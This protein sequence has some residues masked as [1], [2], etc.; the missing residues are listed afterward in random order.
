MNRRQQI[1]GVDK[2]NDEIWKLW[3]D[4]PHEAGFIIPKFI[5]EPTKKE[6]LLFLGLNPS[7]PKAGNWQDHDK[8]K[9]LLGRIKKLGL[10][11][12]KK[13]KETDYRRAFLWGR[14]EKA[15]DKDR[16]NPSITFSLQNT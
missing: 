12:V 13:E 2:I 15:C 1:N 4:H 16:K 14:F 5:K 10:F 11:D 8:W 7:F 6:T 9:N 3:K